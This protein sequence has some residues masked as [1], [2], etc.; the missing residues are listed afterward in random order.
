M[1]LSAA[2]AHRGPDGDGL[3]LERGASIA[4]GHRRLSIV[5]VA[6][7]QQ[8]MSTP[9]G[10][11]HL[12]YN[13]EIYNHRELRAELEA[14][15][16]QFR[17]ACDTEVLLLGWAAWGE[18]LLPRLNGIFAFAILDGRSGDWQVTLVR[19]PVG[20]K[21]M[22]L[23]RY[24]EGWWFASELGAARST[25]LVSSA[26]DAEALAQFLVYR[27]IP[28]PRTAYRATWKL[29]AG[30]VVRLLPG[31]SAAPSFRS[32]PRG[33][34]PASVPGSR[35]E[36]E[37]ALRGGIRQAVRRQLMS[38]VPVGSLLSGGVDSTVVTSCMTDP[39]GVRP[40]CFAIGFQSEPGGGELAEAR[41]AAEALGVRLHETEA[42]DADYLAEWPALLRRL[43]EPIANSGLLLVG[44]LCETIHRTHKVV[45]S[46]Q[47]ADEP[48]GGYP[49][50]AA[51]RWAP[52]LYHAK[53]LL[54]VLPERLATSDR[55]RRLRRLANERVEA[56]WM[57]EAIGVFGLGEAAA[58]S[59]E[60]VSEDFLVEPTDYALGLVAPGDD[61]LN[62]LLRVDAQLSLSNDLLL[63]ADHMSMAHSVEV[64]VP[65][66]DLELLALVERMPSAYKVS[67]LGERKWLYRRAVAP[68]L[69]PALR[70]RL[71]GPRARLGR[72][73]GFKTPLDRWLA[74]WVRLEADEALLG[75]NAVLPD[76]IRPELMR[77]LL[78]EARAGRPRTR[79]LASLHAL[80]AWLQGHLHR[81]VV[82]AA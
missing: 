73:L 31:H 6:G 48:L 20:V 69:P 58:L 56:R 81:E 27:F 71:L 17:T 15:G 82:A 21:P 54:S 65:F 33:F 51:G 37:E 3:L 78:D 79:Q 49:R 40:D 43:G 50:H 9:D 55:V 66:L 32:F 12:V 1:K 25:G 44:L 28:A 35:A 46:G 74:G 64:R 76:L 62:R 8:P 2:L 60:P 41:V 72:K 68:M 47:G 38:D 45:L 57:T 5:D 14:E 61:S 10:R 77:Q 34:S 19:D 42:S 30:H 70:A 7:G 75:N 4:L 22:Y 29:P 39:E 67:M 11:L 13:G 63:V 53:P 16:Y 80:E 36:W 59:R 52:W 26:L 18:R 23:G 24:D